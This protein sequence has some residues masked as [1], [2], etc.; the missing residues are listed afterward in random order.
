MIT[1]NL[2]FCLEDL[3]LLYGYLRSGWCQSASLR[4]YRSRGHQHNLHFGV[5][6]WPHL[7]AYRCKTHRHVHAHMD[8]K[9]C[10]CMGIPLV[11]S[12]HVHIQTHT[13]TNINSVLRVLGRTGGQGWQTH[14]DSGWSGRD[15]LLCDCHDSGPQI[16]GLFNQ[17]SKL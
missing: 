15:V 5:R 14:S 7:H 17:I 10:T 2:T 13:N 8:I 11:S 3:L 12:T 6:E 9:P 16:P 1:E 4:H